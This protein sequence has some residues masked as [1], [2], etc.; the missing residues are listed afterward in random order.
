MVAKDPSG[1]IQQLVCK[2]REQIIPVYIVHYAAGARPAK[3]AKAKATKAA[4]AA[5]SM[6]GGALGT[7]GG[8]F[9]GGSTAVPI[10]S[11]GGPIILAGSPLAAGMPPMAMASYRRGGRPKAS[12]PSRKRGRVAPAAMI[13]PPPAAAGASGDDDDQDEEE[14]REYAM[15]IKASLAAS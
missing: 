10:A 13:M 2:H 4:A 14:A 3:G 9:A 15:A 8:L 5:M 6:L 1:V 12:K 11:K 7:F